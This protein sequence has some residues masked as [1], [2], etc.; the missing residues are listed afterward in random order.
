MRFAAL[1]LAA[2]LMLTACG[3]G[4]SYQKE[5]SVKRQA[6]VA[7]ENCHWEA[8]HERQPDGTFIK[9]D[10]DGDAVDAYVKEC[11][12]EKG[13]EYKEEPGKDSSWWPF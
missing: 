12:R 13:Y 1:V 8:T 11:M 5:G 9:V 7:L 10:V 2:A 3:G 6:D 4:K